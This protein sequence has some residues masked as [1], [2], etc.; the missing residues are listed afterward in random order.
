MSQASSKQRHKFDFMITQTKFKNPMLIYQSYLFIR[1]NPN[2]ITGKTINWKCN[3]YGAGGCSIRAITVGLKEP[4]ELCDPH[5]IGRSHLPDPEEIKSK[6]R[7]IDMMSIA[8]TSAEPPRS[9]ISQCQRDMPVELATVIQSDTNLRQAI[10]NVRREKFGKAP[11]SRAEIELEDTLTVDGQQFFL[12]DSGKDDEDRVMVFAT[13]ENLQ[14]LRRYPEWFI[15]GTFEICPKLFKQLFT[16][17]IVVNGFNLPLIYAL[18]PNKQTETYK[19]LFQMVQFHLKIK[20]WDN[21]CKLI[22]SLIY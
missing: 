21:S 6:L 2:K 7:R 9:I 3:E 8:Q 5:G 14:M 1:D 12:D 4:V 20:N 17:Q 15:D 13:Q 18:L 22:W 16:F 10:Q 19:K 11:T